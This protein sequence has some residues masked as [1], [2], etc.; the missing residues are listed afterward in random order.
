MAEAETYIPRLLRPPAQSFF[1]FGPRG[2]GKSTWVGHEMP[3]AHRIDLLDE[4]RYQTY[5]ARVGAFADE[6]RALKTRSTVVVDEIQRLP[7]LLN[8]VHRFIEDRRLRFVLCGSSARKL[9]QQGTNLLAGRALRRALHPFVPAELG[10]AFDLET[11]LA[12]G[13]L[14]VIWQAP[15]R[16]EAL[17]AYVQLYLREEVQAEALVRNLPGF[18][19]FLPVAALFHGQTLNVTSLARDAEVSRMTVNGYLEIVEDTLLAFRLPAFEGRMRVRE[20]RHPKL[21]WV[22]AGVVRALKRQLGP[23]TAE[24]RGT[25]FEGWVANLLRIHNDY[26]DLFDE[27]FCWAPLDA[28]RTEVD[29]LLRRGRDWLAIEVKA[30]TGAGPD[31]LRGLRAIT[32]LK[33]LRR[34]ILVNR[35]ERRLTTSDGIDVWPVAHLVDALAHDR[36]WP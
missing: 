27:W 1:L 21:Y 18:A 5:L 15:S 26:R 36:L 19:R 32:D 31:E 24:E 22:D 10:R 9:K 11:A 33:G 28:A 16:R 6:L 23:V 7:N 13:T 29:F 4:T 30:G 25:L 20:R 2:A 8:E 34:R 17:T 12:F 14:P 3:D 35:G